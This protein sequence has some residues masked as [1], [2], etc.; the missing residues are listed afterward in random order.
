[1][2]V[3]TKRDAISAAMGLAEDVADGKLTPAALESQAIE[4]LRELVGTVV[5]P[6]DPAWPLQV[7]VAR[8]VLALDG[9]PA[10]ELAEWAAV[11][12]Q[13]AGQADL[14][15]DPPPVSLPSAALSPDSGGAELTEPEPVAEPEPV[16]ELADA[17]PEPPRR[18]DL[19]DPLAAWSPS[20]SLHGL[21]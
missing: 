9:I 19:Y 8:Q 6:D 16:P 13:R 12:R 14:P 18:A 7:D 17:G 5:G 4:E 10:T 11:A 1:M 2:T 15:P 20:R 21:G 3:T